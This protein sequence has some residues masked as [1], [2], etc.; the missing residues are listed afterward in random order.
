[1]K[2]GAV[3]ARFPAPLGPGCEVIISQIEILQHR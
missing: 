1:M 3:D 2:S